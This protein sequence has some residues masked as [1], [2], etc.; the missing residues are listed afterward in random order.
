MKTPFPLTSYLHLRVYAS[1][2]QRTMALAIVPDSIRF[3][4]R[5]VLL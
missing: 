4:P 1:N 2:V 5:A 3:L